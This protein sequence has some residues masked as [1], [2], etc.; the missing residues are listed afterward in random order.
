ML[1]NVQLSLFIKIGITA[2]INKL[3]KMFVK[4]EAVGKKRGKTFFITKSF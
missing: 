2:I 1:L 3:L 4:Q